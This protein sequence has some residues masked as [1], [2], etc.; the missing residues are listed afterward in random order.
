MTTPA[1]PAFPESSRLRRLPGSVLT[2]LRT[3]PVS[4]GTATA[5]PTAGTASLHGSPGEVLVAVFAAFGAAWLASGLVTRMTSPQPAEEVAELTE[6]LVRVAA[7]ASS[8][9]A[10]EALVALREE[11][12]VLMVGDLL[13]VLADYLPHQAPALLDAADRVNAAAH[14]LDTP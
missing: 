9:R 11:E 13:E 3:Q 2:W 7:C 8:G 5:V 1:L 14:N 6:A 4:V 12:T 10:G